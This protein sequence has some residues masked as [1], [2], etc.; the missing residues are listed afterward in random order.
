M[1]IRRLSWMTMPARAK[2]VLWLYCLCCAGS[3]A[4]AGAWPRE[5]GTWFAS[6]LVRLSWPQD[7][8]TWTSFA[9]TSRYS[10]VFVEYGLTEKIT[11]GLDIGR[12]ANGEGKTIG[13]LR[14]PLNRSDRTLKIAAELGLGQVAGQAVIR[15]GL[16]LGMGWK[17]GWLAA[18]ALA[19]IPVRTR[20]AE[21]KL[22]LTAGLNLPLDFKLV[23][24]MQTG[25]PYANAPYAKIETTIVTPAFYNISAQVGGSWGLAG[26]ETMGMTFGLWAQF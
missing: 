12:P 20:A 21:L 24:Q 1:P 13:F 6:G 15:P 23:A 8:T 22:D 17:H 18:D 4:Q 14:Y 11:A 26:D 2:T 7:R 16:M 10:S 25:R 5:K 9:P 19:E 3:M